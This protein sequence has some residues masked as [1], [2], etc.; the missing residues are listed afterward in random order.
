MESPFMNTLTENKTLCQHCG[1][2]EFMT[3]AAGLDY[4]QIIDGNLCF[5]RHTTDGAEPHDEIMCANCGETA[6]E[7]LK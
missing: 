5:M 4:Y 3:L 2:D 7:I 6:P 1:H